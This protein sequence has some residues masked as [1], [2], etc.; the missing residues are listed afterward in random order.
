MRPGRAWAGP[1]PRTRAYVTDPCV[2]HGPVRMSRTCAYATDPCAMPRAGAPCHGP[3]RHATNLC[4]YHGLVRHMIACDRPG[5]V[6]RATNL[7]VCHGPVR[8]VTDPCAMSRTCAIDHEM[9]YDRLRTRA[10]C[11]GPA[12]A[13]DLRMSRTCAIDHEMVYDRLRT[14]A[15]ATDRS[16]P[17]T[18]PLRPIGNVPFG[19]I[20]YGS[21]GVWLGGKTGHVIVSS[22]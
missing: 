14:R 6:C 7:C 19:P 11:H 3:V 2:C 17:Q 8:H 12:Y 20:G 16:M 13:T 15:Y 22:P 10:P 21:I 1:M 9:V 4:V 18:S 5:T